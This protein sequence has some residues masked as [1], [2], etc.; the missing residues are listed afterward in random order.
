MSD[1]LSDELSLSSILSG[2]QDISSLPTVKVESF[3]ETLEKP[4]LQELI[5]YLS[6]KISSD[7]ENIF[8]S[9]FYF[10]R[11]LCYRL[12]QLKD[13]S[14]SDYNE[15]INLDPYVDR[16]YYNRAELSFFLLSDSNVTE[17]ISALYDCGKAIEF[18]NSTNIDYFLLR[19]SILA[20]LATNSLKSIDPDGN[21]NGILY[22]A[23]EDLNFVITLCPD[24]VQAY[25]LRLSCSYSKGE[26]YT[27]ILDCESALKLLDIKDDWFKE[28]H[29]DTSISYYIH[30]L[31]WYWNALTQINDLP[32][33]NV[34]KCLY[35]DTLANQQLYFANQHLYDERF[36]ESI[37]CLELALDYLNDCSAIYN[38]ESVEPSTKLNSLLENF[39]SKRKL[40]LEKISVLKDFK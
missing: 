10:Y 4:S 24:N 22:R 18:R 11:G 5:D 40:V 17:K 21:S 28:K 15:A 27:C 1:I 12:L 14:L 23:I 3:I 37:Q 2:E 19:A 8:Y 26:Y 36:E 32:K 31:Y 33:A 39:D 38:S 35:I 20:D 16:Y 30:T 13:N 25:T 6:T 34:F 9:S 29:F 7:R